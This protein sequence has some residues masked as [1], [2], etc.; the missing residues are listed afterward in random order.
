MYI[1]VIQD[2]STALLWASMIGH[3]VMVELLL[4]HGADVNAINEV[5]NV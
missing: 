5:R 1:V 4:Q 3:T 2:G